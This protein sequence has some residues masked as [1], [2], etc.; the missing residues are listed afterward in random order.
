M[1]FVRGI[2]NVKCRQNIV[3]LSGLLEELRTTILLTVSW[4]V[5][6]NVYLDGKRGQYLFPTLISRTS[7]VTALLKLH[8]RPT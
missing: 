8:V 7:D 2:G 6:S 1:S 5:G 3:A 4:Q